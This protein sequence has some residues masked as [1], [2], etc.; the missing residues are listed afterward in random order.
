MLLQDAL[1]VLEL[2]NHAGKTGN[3]I[4]G[5]LR[6]V[7]LSK[8]QRDIHNELAV[9]KKLA[10]LHASAEVFDD[11]T[12]EGFEWPLV[13]C[14]GCDYCADCTFRTLHGCPAQIELLLIA[15]YAC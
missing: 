9:N 11:A 7:T 5:N 1:T 10:Q 2:T 6:N 8:W 13:S 12:E 14:W 4:T 3:S 15:L